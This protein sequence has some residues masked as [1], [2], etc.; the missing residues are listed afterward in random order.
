MHLRKYRLNFF[1]TIQGK[2]VQFK[3]ENVQKNEKMYTECEETVLW[4]VYNGK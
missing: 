3:W 1:C 4:K 2:V